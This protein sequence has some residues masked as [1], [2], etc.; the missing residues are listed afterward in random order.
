LPLGAD[1]R[2]LIWRNCIV[3][4]V[5][6]EEFEK[7]RDLIDEEEQDGDRANEEDGH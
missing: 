7:R 4:T 1:W 6:H 5:D 3:V 2:E